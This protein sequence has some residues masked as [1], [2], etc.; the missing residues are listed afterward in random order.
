ACGCEPVRSPPCEFGPVHQA[1]LV[2]V[3][4]A[5]FGSRGSVAGRYSLLNMARN[6][7]DAV[8]PLSMRSLASGSV[9]CAPDPLDERS[10]VYHERQIRPEYARQ[11]ASVWRTEAR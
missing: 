8:I 1:M 11:R 2:S 3:S 5:T 6:R 7:G 4:Q 9:P 10:L